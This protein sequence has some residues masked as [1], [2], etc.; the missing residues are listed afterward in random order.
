MSQ[1][2]TTE[3]AKQAIEDAMDM[4]HNL[5]KPKGSEGARNWTMS[6]PARRDYDPDL[7]ISC[8]LMTAKREIERLEKQRDELLKTLRDIAKYPV[9][10]GGELSAAGL[11]FVAREAI[12]KV[13]GV[14]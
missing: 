14:V 4:I 3:S 8:G 12:A 2:A 7:V 1:H 13:Q 11:R 10:V 5:C 6:I 9:D